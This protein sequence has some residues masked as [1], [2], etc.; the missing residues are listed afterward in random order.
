M[1][2]SHPLRSP[3]AGQAIGAERPLP[4]YPRPMLARNQWINL[5]GAWQFAVVPSTAADLAEQP[6]P[7]GYDGTI[8]VPFAIETI[9]SGVARDLLPDQT[10]FY[11]R[12]IH[13]PPAWQAGR[14]AINFEAVD[15]ECVVWIDGDLAGGHT[16]GYLP[17][18]IDIADSGES[19]DVVVAVRDPSDTGGQPYGKQA[20]A[21][22]T[23]WYTATSGIWGTVW[24]EPLPGNAITRIHSACWPDLTGLDVTVECEQP[25]EVEVTLGPATVQGRSGIPI[26][27]SIPDAR[28]WSPEDPHLY[29]VTATTGQDSAE[30]WAAVRTVRLGPIPGA[31]ATERPAVLLNGRPILLNTPLDQGYW[32]ETG[33]TPP[34]EDALLFDLDYLAEAGFN[35]VRTHIKVES[36]RFYH[37]A[38]Q[39]GMLIVQ[40]MVNGG[41]PRVD[42][43][44]S[45]YV[46]ALGIHRAD[47][48]ARAL[49]KSGRADP[50]NRRAFEAHVLDTVRHLEV[51]PS[52]VAW[53]TFNEAWGQYDSARIS[54]MIRD[55]DPTRPIDSTSGWYDQGGGDFRSRH[56]YVLALQRP[57][58]GDRRPYLISEFG[59]HNLRIEGHLW[60]GADEYG[61]T[62][63]SS[64]AELADALAALYRQQ[65]IPL[66]DDGLRGCVYTQVSDVEIE[67][68]GLLTYDRQPKLEAAVLRELNQELYRRFE[69]IGRPQ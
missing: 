42:I 64:P 8:T 60:P 35:G 26:A 55:A 10:L 3:W 63:H 62:F 39:R 48:S 1:P 65:L 9:A 44:Q 24:A 22:G 68:N 41:R 49:A 67:T 46:M 21:P 20:L 38:D 54:A 17:F 57:P 37:L 43:N 56:R 4:E 52:V 27:V 40:D 7:D 58:R 12:R 19:H 53:V 31:P 15:H 6:W 61:Y 47:R 11:R 36:R 14:V 2:L 59:G 69:L 51:H 32:P 33:M 34:S 66:V 45:R 28:Q 13:V 30:S 29:P 23:I 5:N 50:E 16:G 18:S 25:A